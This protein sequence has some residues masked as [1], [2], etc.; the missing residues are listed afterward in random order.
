MW[1]ITSKL[2]LCKAENPTDRVE[3]YNWNIEEDGFNTDHLNSSATRNNDY[4]GN[5]IFATI[6]FNDLELQFT[7]FRLVEM[8]RL[9][10]TLT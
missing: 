7:N 9:F 6:L 4:Y 2:T 1:A 3:F 10:S 5:K 8:L